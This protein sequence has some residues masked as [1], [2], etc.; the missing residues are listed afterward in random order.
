[1]IKMNVFPYKDSYI[2]GKD[3]TNLILPAAMLLFYINNTSVL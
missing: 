1:M 2:V 3:T